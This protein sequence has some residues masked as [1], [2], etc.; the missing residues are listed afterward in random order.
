MRY[1][2][3]AVCLLMLSGCAKPYVG[4]PIS[5]YSSSVCLTP[6]FPDECRIESLSNFIPEFTISEADSEGN[7]H[8][9][10]TF[11]PTQGELKSWSHIVPSDSMIWMLFINDEEVFDTK[12]ISLINTDVQSKLKFKFKYNPKGIEIEGV[13]ITYKLAL[14]G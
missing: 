13:T 1:A 10:G 7:H 11:D 8:I 4:N 12:I 14:E 9:E 3:I 5:V 2:I 6:M